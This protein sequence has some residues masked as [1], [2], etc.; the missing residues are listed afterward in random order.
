MIA[1]LD[2]AEAFITGGCVG[3]DVMAMVHSKLT[4]REARQLLV[5]PG[6]GITRE[7]EELVD[8][9]H[10]H[11]WR[12]PSRTSFLDRNR[13]MVWLASELVAFPPTRQERFRGS[14]TWATIRYAR[15]AGIP[16]HLFPLA[17]L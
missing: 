1:G 3:V 14:G 4:H 9:V 16:V 12:L 7:V 8:V 5:V 15:Q 11:V 10:P 2:R 6:P 13:A 17:E